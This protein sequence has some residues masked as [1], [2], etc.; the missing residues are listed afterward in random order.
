MSHPEPF[1]FY[2]ERRLVRL[3]GRKATTLPELLHHL[4]EVSGSSVFYHTHHLYLSHHFVTPAFYND[5]ATWSLEALLEPELAERLAAIDLLVFTAIRPLR[6]AIADTIG[7]HLQANRRRPRECP[8]GDEFHFCE[9]QSFVMATG[10]VAE[11]VAG[12][13][14]LLPQVTTVSLYYHFFEARLRLHRRT[15]DFSNWLEGLGERALA[16]AIDR[17]DPYVVTLDELKQQIL[18]LG[19]GPAGVEHV[20]HPA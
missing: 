7:R 15:N 19:S 10:L 12:F 20:D 6:T 9:S 1:H 14:R 11:D 13:F 8:P 17:L 5:F 18:R 2:T 3:T 16:D 4:R